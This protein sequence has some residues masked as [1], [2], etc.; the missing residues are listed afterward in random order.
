MQTKWV[1]IAAAMCLA[2][3][4]AAQLFQAPRA[5]G[6]EE[7]VD[8]IVASVDG[9]PI[10]MQEVKDFAAHN[11][12]PLPD[13]D[14]TTSQTFKTALKALIFSKLL[15]LE[16]KKYEDKVEES[17][18]DHYIAD[19]EKDKGITDQQ[20][21][22]SLMQSGVSYDD[23]RK[24]A[25]MELEKAMMLNEGL[26]SKIT[27]PAA[28]IRA[29]YNS[30]KDQ[31]MVKA[32]RY[33]LAQI[34]IAVAPGATPAQVAAAKAK[35]DDVRQKALAGQDFGELARQYSDD[36]SKSQGGELGSFAPNEILDQILA[37]IRNLPT[38]KISEPIRTQHGFHIVKVEE[39]EVPGLK[40]FPEVKEDIRNVLIDQRAKG[41][42]EQWVDTDLVKQ[43]N[44]ETMY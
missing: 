24:Q 12:G 38:G 4:A 6:A 1:S 35:A 29:Y 9:D 16:M 27:I 41:R 19:L 37:A 25:R 34:M 14:P 26:R 42:L 36:D 40:P 44:V 28:D 23:F 39:H 5:L 33:Q 22:E 13:A 43:H 11:G 30:H 20:L 2:L 3:A 10:T 32:E 15:D 17:Q 31:F 8:R 21:K 18:I 7:Y